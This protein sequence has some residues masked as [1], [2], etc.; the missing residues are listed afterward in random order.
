MHTAPV[1]VVVL[2]LG[3]VPEARFLSPPPPQG[4][5]SISSRREP[6]Y[7]FQEG[8]TRRAITLPCS[9]DSRCND[10]SVTIV[11]TRNGLRK[12]VLSSISITF[13]QFPFTAFFY[14]FCCCCVFHFQCSRKIKRS[15]VFHVQ[16]EIL[17]IYFLVKT[18]P[19]R[20]V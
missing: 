10:C 8:W 7:F 12:V 18:N 6:S 16:I 2:G 15:H 20:F 11:T 14:D 19:S 13:T 17:K 4:S 3:H 5:L 1:D 9:R